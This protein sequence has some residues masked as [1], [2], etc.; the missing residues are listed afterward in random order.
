[1]GTPSTTPR[2]IFTTLKLSPEVTCAVYTVPEPILIV[3]MP[4]ESSVHCTGPFEVSTLS[5]TI[6]FGAGASAALLVEVVAVLLLD[7]EA[8]LE[9]ELADVLLLDVEAALVDELAD[10]L[11]VV[12]V[13][14]D[15]G[16]GEPWGGTGID[17]VHEVMPA[18]ATTPTTTIDRLPARLGSAILSPCRSPEPLASAQLSVTALAQNTKTFDLRPIVQSIAAIPLANRIR[19]TCLTS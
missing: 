8:A 13:V 19:L 10:V 14:D 17:W 9:D 3:R 7:V 2:S 15:T 18:A 1:M 11:L 6:T 16:V 4:V 5:P 12:V